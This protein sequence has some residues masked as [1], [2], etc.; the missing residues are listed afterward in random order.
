MSGT[1]CE[2]GRTAAV[3]CEHIAAKEC[4]I[5]SA[6]RTE[7]VEPEDSGWQFFCGNNE[8]DPEKAKVSLL[9]E[10]LALEPSLTAFMQE[11]PGVHVWRSSTES[12]WRVRRDGQKTP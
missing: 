9:D 4:S 8:E 11:A 6:F 5:L 1:L 7:P 2:L 10:V 12:A 3:V